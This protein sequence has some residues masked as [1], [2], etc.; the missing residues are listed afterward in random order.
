MNV[1]T[2]KYFVMPVDQF[3]SVKEIKM[4]G[5]NLGIRRHIPSKISCIR[6][7]DNLKNGWQKQIT[8]LKEKNSIK[9]KS[10]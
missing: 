2:E 10:L 7:S 3:Y 5:S 1:L 8:Q 6:I 9:Q 4:E